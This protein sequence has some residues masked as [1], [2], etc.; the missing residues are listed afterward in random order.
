[1]VSELVRAREDAGISKRELSAR[2]QRAPNFVHF[3]E[4]GNRLLTLCEFIEYLNALEANPVAS[5][6][7]IIAAATD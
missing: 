7:R 6:K 5:L 2:L 3:V 1:M 4:S